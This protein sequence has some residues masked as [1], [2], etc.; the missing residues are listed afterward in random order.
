MDTRSAK[1]SADAY[2]CGIMLSFLENATFLM[3]RIFVFLSSGF[4]TFR[5]LHDLKVKKKAPMMSWAVAFCVS[6][7]SA[8]VMSE[9]M[10]RG[11]AFCW[12]SLVSVFL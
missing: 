9:I 6:V 7:V 8:F 4:F 3:V 10:P 12:I 5:Y 2:K 11:I 1:L